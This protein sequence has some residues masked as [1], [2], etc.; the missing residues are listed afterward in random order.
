MRFSITVRYN[1][2]HKYF[3]ETYFKKI[4]IAQ[5]QLQPESQYDDNNCVL[6]ITAVVTETDWITI[7]CYEK[8]SQLILCQ[9]ITKKIDMIHNNYSNAIWCDEDQLFIGNKCIKF[10]KYRRLTNIF[11]LKK[12]NEYL[13]QRHFN[14]SED[15][16]II[17]EYFSLIQHYIIHPVHFTLPFTS[18]RNYITYSAVQSSVYKKLFWA[19]KISNETFSQYDG[20]ILFSVPLSQMKVITTLFHCSN[21]SYVDETLVCNGIKDCSEGTDEENYFCN[22]Y[23]KVPLS[24]CKYNCH[25]NSKKCP[26]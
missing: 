3:Y 18:E 24:V 19:E 14:Q 8:N 12:M 17:T 25:P 11:N 15:M 1:P 7:P 26:C 22:I 16:S 20:Y 6:M 9:K 2:L 13:T 5:N 4:K 10:K 21:D 23:S